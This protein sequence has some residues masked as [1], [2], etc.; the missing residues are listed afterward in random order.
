[1]FTGK[2]Y[3]AL[4]CLAEHSRWD[5]SEPV[6]RG[7]E[8]RI[9]IAG[10]G[11]SGLELAKSLLSEDKPVALIDND[12]RA[13]KRA[14]GVDCLVV[15]GDATQRKVLMEAGINEAS[16]F[17]AVTNSDERNILACSLARHAHRIS[18]EKDSSRLMTICRVND[19]NFMRE[20]REGHLK[21]W[22][23]VDRVLHPVDGSVERLKT[24]LLMTCFDEVIPFGDGAFILE[25]EITKDAQ[26]LTFT[27]LEE[28]SQRI[29]DMPVIVGMKRPGDS[30][31]IPT[32]HTQ[33]LPKDK[34]AVAAIGKD[35]FTRI[36]R[37]FGHDEV[38]FTPTPRVAIFGAGLVSQR[39]AASYL[40]DGC[41]VTVIESDL[42]KANALSGTSLGADSNLDIINGDHNDP[43]LLG[44]IELASHDVA[45]GALDN[46]HA[47]IA[48]VILAS[49]LG[50]PRTGLILSSSDMVSVVKKMG[51]TF[52]VD[53]N[54]VSVDQILASIHERLTGVYGVLSTI[55]DIVGICFRIRAGS[56][57]V[58]KV[59]DDLPLSGNLVA[60]FLQ[61]PS[62]D[63]KMMTLRPSGERVLQPGD[64]VI[65]FAPPGRVDEIE[66]RLGS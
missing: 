22:A 58:S 24:G 65:I 66:R 1:M 53:R 25:M 28:V 17:I 48:A 55:P 45:I 36:V 49:E 12:P 18:S 59:V 9:V 16:V 5:E 34:V 33:L 23:G 35:S 8:L 56:Q 47:S 61:R 14:Q 42:T 41:R 44:E 7:D 21:K 54:R 62:D 4:R 40:S 39:V 10:A 6:Q 13:I 26:D 29:S 31:Y 11:R 27:S 30:P 52:A 50:V 19:P 60:A 57:Y 43:E 46:D 63:G 37:L 15:H 3:L 2:P 51:I 38:D 32:K 20:G 64:R